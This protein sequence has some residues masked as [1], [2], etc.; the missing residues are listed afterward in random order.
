[1]TATLRRLESQ[2]LV[3]R[4]GTHVILTEAGLAESLLIVR[5][6]RVAERFL[7]DTL[8]LNW[9]DAHEDAC[10]LEH[11]LS[12][13]VLEAL[14]RFLGDPTECPHGHPIPSAGGAVIAQSGR[15]LSETEPGETV[16]VLRVAED[17]A[18]LGYLGELG[19][20]PDESVS[21]IDVQPHGGP[22]TISVRGTER[23]VAREVA[24]LVT[25]GD[26]GE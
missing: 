4:E 8:G 21:V 14:E 16:R 13:R 1:V 26:A 18:R 11:S 22:V 2:G 25:V 3:T 6:H 7:V 23:A 15:L 17:D 19:L 5:K 10:L 9:D 12:P 24:A 20:K